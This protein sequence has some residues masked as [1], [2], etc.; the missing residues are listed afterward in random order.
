MLSAFPLPRNDFGT[1]LTLGLMAARVRADMVSPEVRRLATSIAA[2]T[3]TT[4]GTEQAVAIRQYLEAHSGFLPDPDGA[5]LLHSPR[6]LAKR[7]LTGSTLYVDCDDIAMLAACLG[8]AVGLKARFI[9]VGFNSPNAPYRHVWTQL[10]A[11]AGG[12]WIECDITRP[13]QG[14]DDFVITRRLVWSV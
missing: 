11:P 4:D 2:S 8:K 13:A 12:P 7:L 9:V 14:L 5:E 1:Y 10:R 6:W 3:G